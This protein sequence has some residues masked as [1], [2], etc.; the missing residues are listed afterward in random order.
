MFSITHYVGSDMRIP[1]AV[2]ARRKS[3]SEERGDSRRTP[4]F[5]YWAAQTQVVV[6]EGKLELSTVAEIESV[7][8]PIAGQSPSRVVIDLTAV[9]LIPNDELAALA[10]MLRRAL[11]NDASVAIVGSDPRSR[12]LLTELDLDGLL[13]TPTIHLALA[14]VESTVSMDGG[15]TARKPSKASGP[16]ASAPDESAGI[17]T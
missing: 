3:G 6:L 5:V 16:S 17:R 10:G 14:S 8:A 13:L 4:P 12:R 11:R 7:V 1:R 2:R 15:A 9:E